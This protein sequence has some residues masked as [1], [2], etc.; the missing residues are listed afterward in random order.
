MKTF[1][2]LVLLLIGCVAV[3]DVTHAGS[4]WKRRRP[5]WAYLFEDTRAR[6]VG[7]V[8]TIIV[9]ETTNIENR[10]IRQ[11]EKETESEV[12]TVFEGETKG[13]TTSRSA[14]LKGLLGWDSTRSLDGNARYRAERDFVD[15]MSVKVI[16]VMPNGNLV[17]EGTRRR[18][19]AGEERIIHVSGIVRP[20]D[21]LDGNLVRSD[22]IADFTIWY[23]GRGVESHFVNPGIVGRLLNAIW[24]F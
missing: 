15:R 18:V 21:I 12:N 1:R 14:S 4:I 2:I 13:E 24:P 8:L 3:P 7:D 19:I 11:L 20:I 10:E 6:R 16:E 22:R 17:V 5:K 9:T 23:E